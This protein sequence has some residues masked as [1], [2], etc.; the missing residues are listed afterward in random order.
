[1][2]LFVFYCLAMFTVDLVEPLNVIPL[3]IY[4]DFISYMGVTLVSGFYKVNIFVH[5]A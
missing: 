3:S 4:I 1:M 2:P 5:I